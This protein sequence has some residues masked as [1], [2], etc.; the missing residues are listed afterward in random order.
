MTILSRVEI[1]NVLDKLDEMYPNAEC[2][3]NYNSMF[4]LLVAVV[5]SAQ[6]T[7]KSVNIVTKELFE[8]YPGAYE[9]SNL[10]EEEIQT[11]IKRIG[12]YKTKSKNL[13]KLSQIIHEKYDGQVPDNYDELIELPGVGRKTANVVLSVG[14]G[15]QRIAVDTHVFR[16]AN[17]IGLVCEKDVLKTELALMK[18]IPEN[19]WTN[20]HHCLIWHGRKCCDARKPNCSEC[21]ISKWCISNKEVE[22]KG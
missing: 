5:L 7:D 12:M 16:V 11:M 1:I 8:K 19:R 14:F 10:T 17:R 15:E 13:L 20:T 6:T 9:I 2:A 4:Q 21:G 3:L 18:V 22:L